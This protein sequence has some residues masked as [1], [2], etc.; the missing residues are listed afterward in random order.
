MPETR[1]REHRSRR[2]ASRSRVRAC[3]GLGEWGKS[4]DGLSPPSVTL[5]SA[6]H[7][8]AGDAMPGASLATRGVAEP[9]PGGYRTRR[10]GKVPGWTFP[11]IKQMKKPADKPGFVVGNHSSGPCVAARLERPTR[12]RRGPRHGSPIRS[13]SGWGL[14]CHAALSPRAVRSCRTISPLPDPL[15]GPSAVCF[16]LHWPSA[17]AA[18]VLPGTLPCGARTFL[19]ARTHRD[20]LADF[21]GKDTLARGPRASATADLLMRRCRYVLQVVDVAKGLS[22]GR[23][24]C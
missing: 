8:N 3:T 21:G 6:L 2:G 4:T 15:A 11:A 1:C 13:C 17:R 9:S 12:E 5:P 10:A 19:D 22:L 16:L 7:G 24:S 18:Q 23:V 20:C 14:P